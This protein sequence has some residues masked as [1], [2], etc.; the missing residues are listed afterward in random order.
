MKKVAV[1][2]GLA[3]LTTVCVAADLTINIRMVIPDA[4]V[5]DVR[6]LMERYPD[7]FVPLMASSN[8]MTV[9]TNGEGVVTRRTNAVSYVVSETVK[10]KAERTSI[11]QL[12]SWWTR[13]MTRYNKDDAPAGTSPMTVTV[14]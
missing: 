7:T 14:Q 12:A 3:V 6:K 1:A 2:V 10:Q 4:K 13:Q 5:S 9:S 11:N 8:V